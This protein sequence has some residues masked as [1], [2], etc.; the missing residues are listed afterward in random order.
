MKNSYKIMM[1]E[2]KESFRAYKKA[3]KENMRNDCKKTRD[4]LREAVEHLNNTDF[5]KSK[6]I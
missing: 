1:K 2:Y 6:H 5:V 4:K 3:H